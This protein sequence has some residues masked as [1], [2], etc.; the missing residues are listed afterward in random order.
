MSIRGRTRVPIPS[1]QPPTIP[2]DD[3]TEILSL[4]RKSET[5]FIR[6]SIDSQWMVHLDNA[7]RLHCHQEEKKGRPNSEWISFA[8]FSKV[9]SKIETGGFVL[10]DTTETRSK[11]RNSRTWDLPQVRT[12]SKAERFWHDVYC[13]AVPALYRVN[14]SNSRGDGEKIE[15]NRNTAPRPNKRRRLAAVVAVDLML[16]TGRQESMNRLKKL[17]RLIREAETSGIPKAKSDSA[18]RLL[19]ALRQ[20]REN[21]VN[22]WEDPNRIAKNNTDNETNGLSTIDCLLRDTRSTTATTNDAGIDGVETENVGSAAT[23]IDERVRARAKEREHDLEQAKASRLDPREE[24]VAIADALYSYACQVLRRKQSLSRRKKAGGET[25]GL[26]AKNRGSIR[27][28]NGMSL[29]PRFAAVRIE[30]E[31]NSTRDSASKCIV[32][33]KEVVENGIPNRSRK[34]TARIM[35]DIIRTLSLSS[36]CRGDS[37]SSS[38][39]VPRFLKWKDLK[40]GKTNGVPIS[41]NATVTIDTN[42]FKKVREILK[43]ER[44]LKPAALDGKK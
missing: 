21:K 5:K 30:D 2:I 31:K 17:R 1:F 23:T 12:L 10:A 27:A 11:I 44:F 35:L 28:R 22:L 3:A 16:V 4:E 14:E 18:L 19:L 13:V 32:T 33:F 42:D 29:S 34:E 38:S 7:L 36:K 15:T 24:R 39:N 8:E 20:E 6:L 26:F 9:S 37:L 43:G 41:K 25:P 40:S